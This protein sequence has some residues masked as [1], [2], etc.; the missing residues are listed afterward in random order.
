MIP[1]WRQGDGA[2]ASPLGGSQESATWGCISVHL[3]AA[4]QAERHGCT[5]HPCLFI[6]S[7]NGYT[8]S[9]LP[10]S[11]KRCSSNA[12][13]DHYALLFFSIIHNV[14]SNYVHDYT[15]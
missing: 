5:P 10:S 9:K 13:S 15:G 2:W 3:L 12:N 8:I 11:K 14:F 6:Q 1:S 4:R 7:S